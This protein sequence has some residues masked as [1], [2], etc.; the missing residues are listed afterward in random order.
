MKNGPICFRFSSPGP[1]LLALFLSVFLPA[2][3]DAQKVTGVGS[4]STAPATGAL[5]FSVEWE[6]PPSPPSGGTEA[7]SARPMAP[8]IDVCTDYG[9]DTVTMEV[10]GSGNVLLSSQTFSCGLHQGTL[11]GIP[12]G[13]GLILWARG[14]V[15]GQGVVWNG[16]SSNFDLAGGEVKNIGKVTVAYTGS[17][18]TPPRVLSVSP[19]NNATNVQLDNVF[20]IAFSERMAGNT[21]DNEAITVFDNG[22]VQIPGTTRY[23]SS[24]NAVVFTPSVP[25]AYNRKH[26]VTVSTAAKDMSGLAMA[27]PYVWSFNAHGQGDWTAPSPFASQGW[28]G[29]MAVSANGDA[30]AVH[31]D[32]LTDAL[33]ATN[34]GGGM[35]SWSSP[36]R[37]DNGA[38]RGI[39]SQVAMDA[40][41]NAIVIY[42]AAT[43]SSIGDGIKAVRYRASDK[44]WE[45][46]QRI[47]ESTP[48]YDSNLSLSMTSGGDALLLWAE[49]G[50]SSPPYNYQAL[51]ARFFTAST[52][53]WGGKMRVDVSGQIRSSTRAVLLEDNGDGFAF[54]ESGSASPYNLLANRFS[55][56][57][58]GTT[59]SVIDNNYDS[60]GLN[61]FSAA[62]GGAGNAFIVWPTNAP[63]FYK[64]FARRY[65]DSTWGLPKVI[66][67]HGTPGGVA[68]YI[69]ALDNND[70][71]VVYHR[72]DSS[73]ELAF[74]RYSP[75]SDSWPNWRF[76]YRSGMGS[77][78]TYVLGFAVDNQANG[79][80]LFRRENLTTNTFGLW[81]GRYTNSDW[82]SPVM[83]T[84]GN[85]YGSMGMDG[86]GNALAT[87]YHNQDNNIYSSRFDWVYP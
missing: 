67:I 33:Y 68:P 83:V 39:P 79:L 20:R 31:R 60:S 36:V 28:Y 14:N 4:G 29:G 1:L 5:S 26:T 84:S 17:D 44:T 75:V 7:L 72:G 82:S 21:L 77:D 54:W 30:V 70:A 71:F 48:T 38:E 41:G 51:A 47:A 69:A 66:D 56:G 34:Y 76:I 35:R 74:N 11:S 16:Y 10:V 63:G 8:A 46:P 6:L 59:P 40:S 49:Y 80:L 81:S 45:T 12:A 22:S 65:S 53:R 85:A 55:G 87:F 58:W 25:L 27:A 64:L 18:V 3:G 86:R 57:A 61:W 50:T 9:I 19:D 52:G 32:R 24:E 42:F 62:L 15:P 23:L 78:N 13:T 73:G 43:L 37:I 2:C